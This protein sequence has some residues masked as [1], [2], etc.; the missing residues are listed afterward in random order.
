METSGGGGCSANRLLRGVLCSGDLAPDGPP[1][2]C[3]K[4]W[5]I[6]T[7]FHFSLPIF[8]FY[9]FLSL[10]YLKYIDICTHL[11]TFFKLKKNQKFDS[12]MKHP[13]QLKLCSEVIFVLQHLLHT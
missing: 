11:N 13:Y 10:F 1:S 9:V 12:H 6:T 2:T 7:F 5:P 3:P 8:F 4:P